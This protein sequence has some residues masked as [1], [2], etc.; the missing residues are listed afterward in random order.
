MKLIVGVDGGASLW[1]IKT[2]L[3]AVD[4]GA[5]DSS[6]HVLKP[7]AH[8]GQS[9]R[10][11][12]HTNRGTATA[13]KAHQSHTTDL[14]QALCDTVLHHVVHL[15]DGECGRAHRERQNGCI[16]R[17]DFAVDRGH[18]QIVGEQIATGVDGGLHLLFGHIQRERQRKTKRNDAR[19]T[20][21]HRA[22]LIQARHLTKLPLQRC[23]DGGRDHLRRG[24]WV[25][26]G[27]L[28]GWVI[29]LRQRADGQKPVG[30]SSGDEH[31]EHHEARRDRA[32]DEKSR[33][34]HERVSVLAQ[35]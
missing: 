1:T 20:G 19:P 27:D 23:R 16:G 14:G 33:D 35:E 24:T 11:D 26:G 29:D 6:S 15:G 8:L 18:G 21:A 28:K 3:G 7:Q 12:L 32:N 34:V 17:I 10:V 4:I 22:H 2:A 9:R 13:S 25:Q 31:R 5:H 30:Q